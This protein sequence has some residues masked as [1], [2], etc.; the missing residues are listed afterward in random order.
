MMQV[1]GSDVMKVLTVYN[2]FSVLWISR[3]VGAPFPSQNPVELAVDYL[4]R[5]VRL[6]KGRTMV[7]DRMCS[8]RGSFLDF[9]F[10]PYSFRATAYFS[11]SSR[12]ALA[13]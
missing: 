3:S 10:L 2:Y 6:W 8:S 1:S 5:L 11:S 12:F 7:Y 4:L 13:F 9:V